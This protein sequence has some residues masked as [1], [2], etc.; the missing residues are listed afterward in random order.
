MASPDAARSLAL[1]DLG[2][3]F[4]RAPQ[5]AAV[6]SLAATSQTVVATGVR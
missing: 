2:W 4:R 3:L 1:S 6:S 5:G